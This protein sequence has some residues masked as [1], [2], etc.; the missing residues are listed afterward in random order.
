MAYKSK[1]T[2]LNKVRQALEAK[3]EFASCQPKRIFVKLC[4]KCFITSPPLKLRWIKIWGKGW[5]MAT[6]LWLKF[7]NSKLANWIHYK[8]NFCLA[9][10]GISLFSQIAWNSNKNTDIFES[11]HYLYDFTVKSNIGNCGFLWD[12]LQTISSL[13]TQPIKCFRRRFP[14]AEL[15]LPSYHHTP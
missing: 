4:W 12:V 9:H 8:F 11:L 6:L 1:N 7:Q 3:K 5:L 14:I 10:T 15:S 13:C 2:V